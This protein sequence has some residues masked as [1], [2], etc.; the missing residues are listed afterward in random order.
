MILEVRQLADVEDLIAVELVC[1]NPRCDG[2]MRI[3]LKRN[4]FHDHEDC[5]SCGELWW[6]PHVRSNVYRLLM[7]LSDISQGT[8]HGKL[9][10]PDKEKHVKNPPKVRLVLPG[11][12][13]DET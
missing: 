7:A 9:P 8:F 2:N 11:R 12:L 13:Q 10:N 6:A 4:G 5:P 1:Q 3:S